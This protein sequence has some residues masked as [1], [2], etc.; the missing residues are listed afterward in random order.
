MGAKDKVAN[1][2]RDAKGKIKEGLGAATDNTRM[3]YE[4]KTEQVEAE[5]RKKAE[6]ARD[7]LT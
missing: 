4:G 7:R 2:A 6:E 3:E 1:E 5:A